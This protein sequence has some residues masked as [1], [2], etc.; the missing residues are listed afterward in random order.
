L[1]KARLTD[2]LPGF[3]E[4]KVEEPGK[5]HHTDKWDRCVQ[6]V[7]KKGSA[8]NAYAVCTAQL[9]P[10]VEASDGKGP[11]PRSTLLEWLPGGK[12]KIAGKEA[13]G[14]STAPA[15]TR[16]QTTE[17]AEVIPEG[18]IK[19]IGRLKEANSADMGNLPASRFEV[20]LLQEGLGNLNDCY[21]YTKEALESCPPLFEGKK[22]FID[23]PDLMEEKTR[24]ERSVRDVAGWFENLRTDVDQD[25]RTMLVGEAVLSQSPDVYPYRVRMTESIA[26]TKTHPGQDFVA[27]S[28]NASGDFD[29]IPIEALMQEDIPA[30][31]LPK[32]Q[33]AIA[34]GISVVRPV[35]KMTSATSCDLVT[36]A[37][38]GGKIAQLLEQ[39][40]GPMAKKESKEKETEKKETKEAAHKEHEHEHKEDGAGAPPAKK[41]DV[42]DDGDHPDKAQDEELIQS[43]MKKYL[44]DGFTDDDKAMAKEAYEA[45]K[46]AC[47]DD[48]DEAMKMAGYSMKMARH[49]KM[50]QSKQDSAAPAPAAAPA[51]EAGEPYPVNTTP[52][53][54]PAPA[55]PKKTDQVE[56]A[57]G[58]SS[59]R[60]IELTAQVAKLTAELEAERLE[61]FVDKTLRESK[62]PMAATKRFRETI[63]DA[64][65]QKEV[66]EKFGWFREAWLAGEGEESGFVLS[67]EKSGV[68]SGGLSFADCKDN[69]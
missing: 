3:R 54:G 41:D 60:E 10:S 51:Q 11:G 46:A 34:Q 58:R 33:E 16:G 22:L 48:H 61:K 44:G 35:R 7:S 26:F 25:G 62:L 14:V 2:Y 1:N 56:S 21:Y 43:M 55:H 28:I 38:A 18:G 69:E 30:S 64:K 31:C 59:K 5:G 42:G 4:S 9:G 37:G 47:G 52:A 36:E 39:E 68:A 29:T 32:I 27:L 50:S 53:A 66:S 23:H 12:P 65:T 20:V 45:A 40:R 57:S 67:A 63:K 6:D 17:S 8:D 15:Q 19:F 13:A 24:P 49:M